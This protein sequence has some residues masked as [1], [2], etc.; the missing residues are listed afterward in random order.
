MHVRKGEE[1]ELSST[2]KNKGGTLTSLQKGLQKE[3]EDSLKKGAKKKGQSGAGE[4]C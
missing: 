3:G 4:G 1:D 2:H